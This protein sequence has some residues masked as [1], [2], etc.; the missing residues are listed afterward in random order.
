MKTVARFERKANALDIQPCVIEVIHELPPGEYKAFTQNMLND[1]DFIR[2]HRDVMRVDRD[3]IT[4]CMLVMGA[5]LPDGVL[6]NSEGSSYGRYTAILPNARLIVES[7]MR[8]E[9]I[10]ELEKRLS[11]ACDE[12]AS[13]ALAHDDAEPHRALLRDLAQK[14][15]FDEKY[16]PL[17]LEM[18]GERP[19]GFAFETD[20]DEL[21]VCR[22]EA[23]FIYN[24]DGDEGPVMNM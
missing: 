10:K 14:H 20:K 16:I 9:C 12:V 7:G 23:D 5:G 3:G 13:C 17:F 22:S 21:I 11:D 18:L 19:E 1:Y 24:S 6:V 15:G 2:E 4:H 8:A